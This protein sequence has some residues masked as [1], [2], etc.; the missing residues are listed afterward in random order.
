VEAAV[1]VAS[2]D[3]ASTATDQGAGP[4]DPAQPPDAPTSG[5]ISISW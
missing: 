1:D 2:A 5:D 4:Q 3:Q